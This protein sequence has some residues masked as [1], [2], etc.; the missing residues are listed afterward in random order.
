VATQAA[1][2]NGNNLQKEEIKKKKKEKK[3]RKA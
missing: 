1:R 3:E 2:P